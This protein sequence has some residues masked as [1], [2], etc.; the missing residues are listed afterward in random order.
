MLF[1]GPHLDYL[2]HACA[3]ISCRTCRF[4]GLKINFQANDGN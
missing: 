3:N 4:N 1:K 2:V